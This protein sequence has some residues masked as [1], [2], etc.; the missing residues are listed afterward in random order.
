MG[1]VFSEEV[2]ISR[3][4]GYNQFTFQQSVVPSFLN[5]VAVRFILYA[6]MFMVYYHILN[7]FRNNVNVQN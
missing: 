5:T 1:R 6:R 7:K 3:V 4:N 2:H